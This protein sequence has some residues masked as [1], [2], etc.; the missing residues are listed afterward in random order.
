MPGSVIAERPRGFQQVAIPPRRV[1]FKEQS[2]KKKGMG[3]MSPLSVSSDRHM[4]GRVAGSFVVFIWEEPC[5]VGRLVYPPLKP[6]L[7]GFTRLTWLTGAMCSAT[8]L[9]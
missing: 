3:R 2:R 9:G 1:H 8:P 5:V 6:K 7:L 4:N